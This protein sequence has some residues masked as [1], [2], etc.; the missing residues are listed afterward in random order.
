MFA[1]VTHIY[2][3]FS[4]PIFPLTFLV[5]SWV[6]GMFDAVFQATFLCS[7][8]LFWLCIYHGVRQVSTKAVNRKCCVKC[9]ARK[10]IR[11]ANPF[12]YLTGGYCG[13]I[14][15]GLLVYDLFIIPPLTIS[16][17]GLGLVDQLT[18]QSCP[19]GD[20]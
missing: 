6:P 19:Y 11:Q 3:S 12:Q 16:H 4:D 20:D 17:P 10:T 2:S 15:S 18:T 7:L 14:V 8:L 5:N 13:H 9:L 1:M